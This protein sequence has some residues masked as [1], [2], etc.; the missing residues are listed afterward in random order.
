MLKHPFYKVLTTCSLDVRDD[1]KMLKHPFYKVLTTSRCFSLD[2]R[3]ML[4]HPF[5]KV[6]TTVS[7]HF[8]LCLNN[9]ET[10]FL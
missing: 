4:K 9:V 10:P 5:Y 6:L 3:E 2:I 1:A 8:V 7:F